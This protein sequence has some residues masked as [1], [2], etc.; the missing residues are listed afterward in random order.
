MGNYAVNSLYFPLVLFSAAIMLYAIRHDR[1]KRVTGSVLF[2]MA[3][4]LGWQITYILYNFSSNEQAIAYF[5]NLTLLFMAFA[6]VAAL[7]LTLLFYG[8]DVYASRTM[9]AVFMVVPLFTAVLALVP[10]LQG[11]LTKEMVFLSV[12]PRRVF[13]E[14]GGWFWV[15]APYCYILI[16]TAFCAAAIKH[17]TLPQNYRVSSRF[18]IFALA[19]TWVSSILYIFNIIPASFDYSLIGSSICAFGVYFATRVNQGMDFLHETR[20]NIFHYLPTAMVILD[21]KGVVLNSNQ[22][23]KEM[24][25]SL[26]MGPEELPQRIGEDLVRLE[27]A[28]DQDAG[29]DYY[30]QT[31]NGAVVYNLRKRFIV[32]KKGHTLGTFLI[33]GEV[34]ENRALIQRLETVAGM[35]AL[36]GI[37]NTRRMEQYKTELDTPENLPLGIIM[38]DLNNLKQV[39]DSLGHQ[40]GDVLLRAVADVLGHCC[41]PNAR[42]GRI[43][44]D[45][46]LILLPLM[47]PYETQTLLLEIKSRLEEQKGYAFPLSLA[48]GCAV[49]ES[50]EQELSRLIAQADTAMYADKRAYRGGK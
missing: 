49:K 40:Q 33:C 18:L 21:N 48:L 32:N 42:L 28:Q 15:H 24:R 39:N 50:P 23:A 37:A 20:G 16:L 43:G 31:P 11:F 5:Y 26:G 8:M 2:L 19:F 38:G 46:F 47:P 44:G 7:L 4:L 41:P 29:D 27:Q 30:I 25:K 35:D 10:A 3:M 6:S 12:V 34:T 45:E 36:T 9:L 13:V 17:R 22:A 1:G 14:R